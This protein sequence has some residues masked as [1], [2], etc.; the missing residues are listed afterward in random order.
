MKGLRDLN[1]CETKIAKLK[2]V[3]WTSKNEKNWG[4]IANELIF[5]AFAYLFMDSILLWHK[6][7]KLITVNL[8]K[9][10]TNLILHKSK[11]VHFLPRQFFP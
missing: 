4:K 7:T 6:I 10:Y 2:F 1:I 11:Q 5:I 8:T 3:N 9:L